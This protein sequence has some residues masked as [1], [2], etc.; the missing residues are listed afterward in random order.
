[1]SQFSS[2]VV[3]RRK[4]WTKVIV[5]LVLVAVVWL[6]PKIQKWLDERGGG[7]TVS[8][9][10]E[11]RDSNP[12]SSMP[13]SG[14]RPRVI[15]KDVDIPPVAEV[16][17]PERT[18]PV[19]SRRASAPEDT[20]AASAKNAKEKRPAPREKTAAS[21]DKSADATQ[22]DNKPV[23]GKLREIR[24]NVFESTA[25]LRYVPG[26]ADDHRLSHVMQHARDDA[27]KPIHGVFDGK[28]DQILG[29]IDEAYQKAKKGGRDVRSENQND[30]LVYTVYLGRRIGYMGGS[31][32][33]RKGNPACRYVRIVL[34]NENVVISAY[35]TKSF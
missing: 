23:L 11:R 8:D 28:R 18:P 16:D 17:R 32:G 20:S 4:M 12:P 19:A 9:P 5:F 30:R 14:D 33:E 7:A 10:V 3:T 25:G 22:A 26:S 2:N 15:I 1:M 27:T 31:E 21:P 34:E 13:A 35:P 24:N 29:V 6:Q